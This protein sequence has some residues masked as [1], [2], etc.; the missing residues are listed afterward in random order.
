MEASQPPAAWLHLGAVAAA[1][2]SRHHWLRAARAARYVFLLLPPGSDQQRHHDGDQ[3]GEEQPHHDADGQ[4]QPV[5]ATVLLPVDFARHEALGD[6]RPLRA[7]LPLAAAVQRDVQDVGA[8]IVAYSDLV[9]NV[10]NVRHV[11]GPAFGAPTA[12]REQVSLPADGVV[13]Q[14]PLADAAVSAAARSDG[15]DGVDVPL[16]PRG[17]LGQDSWFRLLLCHVDFDTGGD[18]KLK[19]LPSFQTVPIIVSARLA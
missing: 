17:H 7:R 18:V 3:H 12:S 4:H 6:D 13:F 5:V 10:R 2:D 9:Y 11:R 8:A 14:A 19:L 1:G 16:S 15:V